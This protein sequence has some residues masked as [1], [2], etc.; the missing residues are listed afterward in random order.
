MTDAA[1]QEINRRLGNIENWISNSGAQQP[2]YTFPVTMQ[3][4][5]VRLNN[6]ENTA[7]TVVEGH[8][9]LA[10]RGLTDQVNGIKTAIDQSMI[11]E[12]EAQE[13]THRG[14]GKKRTKHS[15]IS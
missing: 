5:E 14:N 6:I 8:L 3:G 9:V 4:L 10:L 1:M 15:W 13:K 7:N 12:S 2:P 11:P